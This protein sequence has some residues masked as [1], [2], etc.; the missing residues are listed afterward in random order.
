MI[1]IAR[2]ETW[3]GVSTLQAAGRASPAPSEATAAH[4]V[5]RPRPACVPAC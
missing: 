2:P 4:T 1:E 5:G 3:S